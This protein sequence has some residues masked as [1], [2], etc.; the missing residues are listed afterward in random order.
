MRVE[1]AGRFRG[2]DVRET[3][4]TLIAILEGGILEGGVHARLV[5]WSMIDFVSTSHQDFNLQLPPHG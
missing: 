1:I 5:E 4:T 2:P 3:G